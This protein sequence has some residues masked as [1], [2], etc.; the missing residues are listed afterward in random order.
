MSNKKLLLIEDDISLAELLIE[1]LSP[2]GYDITH[3]KNGE[4]GLLIAL[5]RQDIDVIL[6][7]VMLPKMDGFEVLNRL[8]KTHFTPVLMLTAKGDDFD[9]IYGLEAGADEQQQVLV[10]ADAELRAHGAAYFIGIG[11][12]PAL[13]IEGGRQNVE[14]VFRCA[15]KLLIHPFFPFG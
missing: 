13:G 15:V 1:Y 5:Q 9:R 6:L 11:R 4:E 2:E 10:F 12:Y 14:T 8:R 7:D 3:A